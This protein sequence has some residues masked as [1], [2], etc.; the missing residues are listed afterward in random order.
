M[1]NKNNERGYNKIKIELQINKKSS[2]DILDKY[3]TT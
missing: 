2:N 3:K 1:Y